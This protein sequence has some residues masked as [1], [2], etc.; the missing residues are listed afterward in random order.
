[1]SACI[2]IAACVGID[3]LQLRPGAFKASGLAFRS[4]LPSVLWIFATAGVAC[5]FVDEQAGRHF[6]VGAPPSRRLQLGF[7]AG[8]WRRHPALRRSLPA[9]LTL[10]I[11]SVAVVAAVVAICAHL[12]LAALLFLLACGS[13]IVHVGRLCRTSPHRPRSAFVAALLQQANR[14]TSSAQAE[15][16]S[17]PTGHESVCPICIEEA[18]LLQIHGDHSACRTCLQTE[19]RSAIRDGGPDRLPVRCPLCR[20]A[21]PDAAV[22]ELPNRLLQQLLAPTELQQHDMAVARA[23]GVALVRCP[24]CTVPM[25]APAPVAAAAA[26]GGAAGSAA[27]AQ[28]VRCTNRECGHAFCLSCLQLPH[29]GRSCATAGAAAASAAISGPIPVRERPAGGA[30]AAVFSAF[31]AASRAAAAAFSSPHLSGGAAGSTAAATS[32]LSATADTA[33]QHLVQRERLSKCPCGAVIERTAGCLHMTHTP[34]QRP[35]R[36]SGVTHFCYCCGTELSYVQGRLTDYGTDQAHY[37]HGRFAP[38]GRRRVGD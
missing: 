36:S 12:A 8:C 14:T 29:P 32:G 22:A 20:G 25:E 24:A 27:A 2:A 13:W 19:S 18:V 21:A 6:V 26:A 17:A 7:S 10:L 35:G 5:I 1:M 11:Q 9:L 38:C 28:R 23:A 34:C 37:P 16:P 4:A 31:N 33:F 3:L 15:T 30:A